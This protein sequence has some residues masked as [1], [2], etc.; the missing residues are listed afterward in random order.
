[1][2]TKLSFLNIS[3]WDDFISR[4]SELKNLLIIFFSVLSGLLFYCSWPNNSIFFLIFISFVPL[5]YSVSLICRDSR[6][7][8]PI[9]VFGVFFLMNLIWQGLGVS[10][11]FDVSPSMYFISFMTNAFNCSL[12]F[13]LIP[14]IYN[15][16]S[17][18]G[19][20]IFIVCAT[21]FMEYVSQIYMF[22]TP[23]ANIGFA[24]GKT[25]WLIQ[26]Y[27][28]IGIEGAAIWIMAVN[29]LIYKLL[30]VNKT[31]S[32]I[33]SLCVLVA[34]VPLIS[35]VYY[36]YNVIDSSD[37][38]DVLIQHTNFSQSDYYRDRDQREIIDSI[39]SFS[40]SGL[41]KKTDLVI[42]PESLVHQL[43]WLHNVD[44]EPLIAHLKMQLN[45]YPSTVIA[46]GGIGFSVPPKSEWSS[47]YTTYN[48]EEDYYY[49][50]NNVALAVSVSE[51]TTIRGKEIFIPFQ[52]RVPYLNSLPFLKFLIEPVGSRIRYSPY[53]S[54]YSETIDGKGNKYLSVLC[55]EILFSR[56]IGKKCAEKEFGAIV[57]HANENWLKSLSGA[58]QYICFNSAIAIQCQK[59]ILRSSNQGISAIIDRKGNVTH[60]IEGHKFDSIQTTINH[61]YHLSFYSH[62]QGTFHVLSGIIC[63]FLSFKSIFYKLKL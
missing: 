15:K 26:H 11:L 62:I 16:Y 63:L 54:S 49:N 35:L 56:F 40:F 45:A 42:W 9:K 32:V 2:R 60:R 22:S 23:C 3:Y 5:I 41:S 6:S 33:I 57:V 24:L 13:L 61:N 21:A 20:L 47:K 43:G 14:F 34:V 36:L 50:V 10:W 29:A 1:M 31:L 8:K 27:S 4:N 25:P 53:Q 7:R 12:P 44:N 28:V 38:S 51:K 59:T 55:Y 58:E 37:S 52:E 48:S 39:F 19:V 30:F 17:I 46:M 18:N